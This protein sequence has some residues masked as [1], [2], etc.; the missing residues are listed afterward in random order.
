MRS[1][2]DGVREV[3]IGVLRPQAK[4]CG[5][6]PEAGKGR[7]QIHPQ[8]A[9]G[10]MGREKGSALCHFRCPPRPAHLP[11]GALSPVKTWHLP[12][13]C[14]SLSRQFPGTAGQAI[15]QS[16]CSVPPCLEPPLSPL[17]PRRWPCGVSY[18]RLRAPG[19]QEACW[20]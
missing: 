10:R 16:P 3:A 13:L 15:G 4:E 19:E 17:I 12:S 9:C 8:S 6:P 11:C 7:E 20:V 2:G 1:G 14:L 5:Q 18:N